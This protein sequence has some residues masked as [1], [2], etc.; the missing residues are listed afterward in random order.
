MPNDT[1]AVAP[2][3]PSAILSKVFVKTERGRAELTQRSAGLNSKQRS[4]LIML[5]GQKQL[6]ELDTPM[7]GTELAAVASVLLERGLV[8]APAAANPAA[9]PPGASTRTGLEPAPATTA[10][11]QL[12]AKLLHIK[13]LMTSSAETYL[14]LM[15]ADVVR[16]VEQAGNEAQLLAVLGHWHMAMRESKYGNNVA[17]IH[18]EHIKASF[19]GKEL[20]LLLPAV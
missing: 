14:G 9:A 15:A 6:V 13:S 5:D 12:S 16:R 8:A 11:A 3:S 4:V 17:E 2:S 10:T 1:A 18:L 19:R 20:D 7:G